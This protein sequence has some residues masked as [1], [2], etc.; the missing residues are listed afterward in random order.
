MN[1]SSLRWI[2]AVGLLLGN[3]ACKKDFLD[4]NT[5]P[6][7]PS[8]ADISLVLPSGQGTVSFIVGGQYNILGEILAQHLGAGGVQYR[9]YD[10]YN[11]NS[12]T[13]DGQFQN[14]YAGAL[15]DYEYVIQEG[16]KSGE[17]RMVGIA[18]I[19]K[20]HTYQILTDLYGDLPFSQALQPTLTTAP[21]YDKQ[22]DIYAGLH[23]LLTEAV[24]NIRQ[25]QGRFPGAAD[26]NYRANS[27]ADMGKWVRL[28]NTLQLKLYVRTSQVDEAGSQAGVR[29]LFNSLTAQDFLH[30]GEDFQFANGTAANSENPFYQANFRLPNNLAVSKTLTQFF[31]APYNDPR[32]LAYF[33]DFDLANATPHG[34]TLAGKPPGAGDNFRWSYPGTYFIGQNFNI[35]GHMGSDFLGV[36][37]TDAP[38]KARPTLLLTYEES[39][40]LRAE[41]AARSWSPENATTLYNNAVAFAMSRYGVDATRSTAFLNNSFNNLANTDPREKIARIARQKW[42]A[43]YGT[44]GLEAWFEARRTANYTTTSFIGN[45]AT[46]DLPGVPLVLPQ[47]NAQGTRFAR[48]LPYPDSELQRNPHVTDTRLTP[49]DVITPVWWDVL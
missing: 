12:S 22:R 7:N 2:A 25:Q 37:D 20:A 23:A 28:A 17:W 21:A 10:Q 26:L 4:V 13:L 27:D 3:S 15:E 31:F 30:P 48:R 1:L 6:N 41:A 8:H 24:A 46:A 36:S 40:F 18:K 34:F 29:A 32:Y 35:N 14:L 49:G 38:A 43:L 39:L 33:I 42:L 47:V 11:L 9:S 45:G 19:L 16:T 44:N 5:D